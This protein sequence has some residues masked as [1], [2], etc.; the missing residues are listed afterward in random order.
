MSAHKVLHASSDLSRR[1]P[2]GRPA[3][4]AASAAASR[5]FVAAAVDPTTHVRHSAPGRASEDPDRA[6]LDLP[7]RHDPELWFAEAP[8]DLERAKTLCA[9]CTIRLACVA[10]AVDRAEYAGVWGGHIFERGRIVPYKRPRGRP[11]KTSNQSAA[12]TAPRLG[13]HEHD[14]RLT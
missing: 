11:R 10:V 2:E 6:A 13:S 8:A 12:A 3:I 4:D 9:G 5:S 7:C 14:G 1:A